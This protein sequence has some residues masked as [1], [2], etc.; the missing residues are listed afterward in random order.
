MCDRYFGGPANSGSP[1]AL[2]PPFA[3]GMP[4]STWYPEAD[5]FSCTSQWL[6]EIVRIFQPTG[7]LCATRA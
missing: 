7:N 3:R 2:R 1:V 5:L 6:L 4:L